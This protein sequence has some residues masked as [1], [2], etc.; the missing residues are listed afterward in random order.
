[1]KYTQILV[2]SLALSLALPVFSFAAPAWEVGLKVQSGPAKNKLAFGQMVDATDGIDGRYDVEALLRGQVQAYFKTGGKKLWR[3]IKGAGSS[4]DL[5][6]ESSLVGE[7]VALSWHPERL[8]QG[9]V[10][11]LHD[12]ATGGVVDMA[13]APNYTYINAGA[14]TLRIEL[15]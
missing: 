3:D 8:P 6:V 15:K 11:L 2:M 1:M 10:I 9:G 13:Q 14:R 4:W 7:T 5:V 12:L